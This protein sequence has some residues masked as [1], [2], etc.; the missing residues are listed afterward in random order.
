MSLRTKI[1]TMAVTAAVAVAVP[2]LASDPSSGTVSNANPKVSWTGKATGYG[3]VPTNILLTTAGE[4]PACPA[5]ACDTFKLTVADSGDL[6]VT[7]ACTTADQFTELH[8]HKPDGSTVYVQSEQ[9]KPAAVKIK[10]AAKGD[11]TIDVLTNDDVTSDGTYNASAEL[12]TAAAP[13]GPA[14]PTVPPAPAGSTAPPPPTPAA[15]LT[16]KTTKLSARKAK[17]A[18]KVQLTASAPVTAVS[19]VLK[20]GSKSVAKA[21]LAK[22]TGT[23][24]LTFKLK[25]KLTPGTYQLVAAAK[26]GARTI[27]LAAKL[28]VTK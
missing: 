11:Y 19:A 3:V 27:G 1:L 6:V 10:S 15:T 17:K 2:A 13:A 12:K 8:V 26:D 7:A 25:K 5:S 24:T 28:K 4:D 16:L 14:V 9:G 20:K 18:P 23:G 22:L 21:S